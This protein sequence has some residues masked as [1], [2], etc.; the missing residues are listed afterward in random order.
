MELVDLLNELD[1]KGRLRGAVI[2]GYITRRV[3]KPPIFTSEDL[4]E[5]GIF[6]EIK[7]A[8]IITRGSRARQVTGSLVAFIPSDTELEDFYELK[9]T[10]SLGGLGYTRLVTMMNFTKKETKESK[11]IW[12]VSPVGVSDLELSHLGNSLYK[13]VLVFAESPLTYKPSN[14]SHILEPQAEIED[15]NKVY[16]N[17]HGHGVSDFIRDLPKKSSKDFE[18][19]NRYLIDPEFEIIREGLRFRV[20]ALDLTDFGSDK[21]LLKYA[22]WLVDDDI[23]VVSDLS[24]VKDEGC[25][26]I[27]TSNEDNQIPFIRLKKGVLDKWGL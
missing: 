21:M 20:L 10:V 16:Y 22:R 2:G 8:Y 5:N 27:L 17:F 25:F 9:G 1:E 4:D 12:A 26:I 14:S 11:T 7:L 18:D 24:D 23:E 3:P 15:S 6:A 19:Q 13:E